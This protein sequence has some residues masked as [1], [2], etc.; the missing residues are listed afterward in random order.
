M[1]Q[2][3]ETI[4]EPPGEPPTPTDSELVRRVQGGEKQAFA[5][6]VHRHTRTVYRVIQG[7]VDNPADAEEIVQEA[8]LKAFQHIQKFRGEAK[9]R[10][11]LIQIAVNESRMRY[12]KHRPGLHDSLDEEPPE[13]RE[14][15]PRELAD[16]RPNPEEKLARK[17]MSLLIGQGIRALPKGYR[18]VFLLRDV[19]HLSNEEAAAALELT[20]AAVKTRL[21]RARLM[22]REYMAPYCKMRW[23]ERLLGRLR[24][25]GRAR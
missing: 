15:H 11:W 7:V 13:G 8:F 10:T 2:Q 24:R 19:E 5:P 9:F 16:W 21:L 3:V 4:R 25:R 12:R 20:V 18:E 17:E 23:P 22:M 6:L 14:F 1:G